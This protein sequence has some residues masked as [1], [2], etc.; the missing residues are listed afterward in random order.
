[1]FLAQR[2]RQSFETRQGLTI[3]GSAIVEVV[4][5]PG[6]QTDFFRENGA[7]HVRGHVGPHSV[8]IQTDRKY[9]IGAT[10]LPEFVATLVTSKIGVESLNYASLRPSPDRTEYFQSETI[11]AE[12]NALLSVEGR[13]R[14]SGW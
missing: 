13:V 6:V 12:W 2:G 1:A 14:P 5:P 10:I 4:A 9:W 8:A 3:V 7:W 11:V